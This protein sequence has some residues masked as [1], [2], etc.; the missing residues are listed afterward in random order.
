MQTAKLVINQG[1][2]TYQAAR[3]TGF[4]HSTI[5]SVKRTQNRNNLVYHSKWKKWHQ[6]PERPIPQRL[7]NLIEIDT[8][9]DGPTDIRLYIY[10]LIDVFSRWA[11]ALPSIHINTHQSLMFVKQAKNIAPFPFSTLQS[12]H[13][14]EFS[15]WFISSLFENKNTF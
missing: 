6:Y 11:H 4:N 12:D 15:K 3:Y 7:G 14:S 10:S 8:I 5:S 1:W 9:L 13:G 2:G